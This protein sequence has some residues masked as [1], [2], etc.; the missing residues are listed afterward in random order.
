MDLAL[1]FGS[2]GTK[3]SLCTLFM[4]KTGSGMQIIIRVSIGMLLTNVYSTIL[5]YFLFFQNFDYF[6]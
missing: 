3:I 1:N 2:G 5:F 4:A 6:L